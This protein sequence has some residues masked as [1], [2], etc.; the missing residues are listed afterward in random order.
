MLLY[1]IS[2]NGLSILYKENTKYKPLPIIVTKVYRYRDRDSVIVIR[3]LRAEILLML[4][5]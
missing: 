3:E 4:I 2:L 1:S 5:S